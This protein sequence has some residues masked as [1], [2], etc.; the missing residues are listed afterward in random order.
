MQGAA[1]DRTGTRVTRFVFTLNN[2]T[3]EEYDYLTKTFAPTVKWLI[4]GKEVGEN[5]TKHLQGACILGSRWAFSKLKTI[6]GL[7]R[8]HIE[9]MRGKPEDSLT[10]CTKEDSQAFVWGTLPTPGRRTDVA[11]AVA[12]IQSGEGLRDLAKDEDGGVAI[13]KFHKGLTVLRS[14]TRPKR[15]AAPLIFWLW[16]PTGVGKTRLAFK[17]GKAI[18]R[19]LDGPPD[20]IWIS[21]GSLR[22]FD[23]YDGQ[24]VAIFDDFRAKHASSFAF[25]LRLF[26][27]WPMSVE[28]KGGFV[29]WT[30]SHIFVTCPYSIDECFSTRKEHVPEDIDQLKRRILGHGGAVYE[31][32]REH[33][34]KADRK[35]FVDDVIGLCTAARASHGGGAPGSGDTGSVPVDAPIGA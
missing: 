7:K 1:R 12:R 8:A 32:E 15:T 24:S 33:S 10:Y 20:D 4:I 22:W 3:Q 31:L 6:V 35:S 26:D 5:G 30:P 21:S 23:G 27:R 17:C 34:S 18:S 25:L 9:S 2:W 29:E 14:L 11:S 13:V 19:L 28:F 16:G